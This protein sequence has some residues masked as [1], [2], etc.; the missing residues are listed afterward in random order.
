MSKI[1]K[2]HNMLVNKEIS[3]KELTLKYIEYINKY[4]KTIN[5]YIST[6]FEDAMSIAGK[7]DTKISR[8]DSISQLEAIPYSL[9]DNLCTNGIKTTC[10]SKMLSEFVP[11]YNSTVADKLSTSILLGKSNMDEF[12]MGSSTE[13]SFFGAVKN[14]YDLLCIPGGSSGG[15]AAAVSADMCVFSIGTDTGGSVRQPAALCGCVGYKPTYGSISRYGL[16]AFASSF[17]TVGIIASTVKDCELVFD[18]IKGLDK[19]DST[20]HNNIIDCFS[21]A[22]PLKVG[23]ITG[24]L[25]RHSYEIEKAINIASVALKD[26]GAL[27]SEVKIDMLKNSSSIYYILSSA[28][29]AS[30]LARFDGVRY[31]YRAKEYNDFEDMVIKSR[32]EAFGMEVKRRIMLGNFVLSSGYYKDFY[33][34]AE[35]MQKS[36][37]YEFNSKFEQYDVILLPVTCE[38][39]YKMGYFTDKVTSM[40]D[41]DYYTVCANLCGFPAISVPCMLSDGGHPIAIQLMSK[42]FDDKR[43]LAIAEILEKQLSLSIKP[44]IGGDCLG[45]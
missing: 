26:C 33:L 9:K 3:A 10:A 6:C 12:A 2:I 25:S 1:K 16:I 30:N 23:V 32:T 41:S 39:Q 38:S 43:L 31:G 22:M 40:Y 8:G 15:S 45:I 42:K 28:Q 34:R 24:G 44:V 36:L 13:T 11:V 7:L 17:D 5:S 21:S 37:I 29:A 27:I 18:A 4:E 35:N 19:K 14:P 20:T